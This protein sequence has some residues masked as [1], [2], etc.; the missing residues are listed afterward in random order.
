MNAPTP[1]EQDEQLAALAGT[2]PETADSDLERAML[3]LRFI[4][5]AKDQGATWTQIGAAL[6]VT[7]KQAKHDAHQLARRTQRQLIASRD[8]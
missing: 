5:E 1:Q 2:Q 6:G 3:R 7:G 4:A 8:S